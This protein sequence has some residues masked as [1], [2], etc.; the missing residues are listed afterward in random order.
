MWDFLHG[1]EFRY[2][3]P[4]PLKGFPVFRKRVASEVFDPAKK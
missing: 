3:H 4:I 1:T 2:I